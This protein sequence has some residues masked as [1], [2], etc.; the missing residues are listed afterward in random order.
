MIYKGYVNEYELPNR[1]LGLYVVENF[2]LILQ[3]LENRVGRCPS[4]RVTGNTA[5]RYRGEDDTPLGPAHTHY[6][7][8]DQ[9]GPSGAGVTPLV[10]SN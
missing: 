2:V 1:S 10:L 9:A 8:F 4:A 5:P 3:R 6:Q 7:G